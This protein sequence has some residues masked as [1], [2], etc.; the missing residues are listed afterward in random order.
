M[1]ELVPGF[2]QRADCLRETIVLRN[3]IPCKST[4]YSP[5]QWVL[6]AWPVKS[7]C[8][9]SNARKLNG[10]LTIL[11]DDDFAD[12]TAKFARKTGAK[13]VVTQLFSS[14][15]GGPDTFAEA[16]HRLAPT[17]P[18]SM[19]SVSE[20]LSYLSQLPSEGFQKPRLWDK[21]RRFKLMLLN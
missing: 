3:E 2:Q 1:R 17:L 21:Q 6:C 14:E 11:F 10:E 20:N 5:A 19:V 12:A 7:S 15:S 4:T 16:L 9:I 13:Q 18:I 8:F